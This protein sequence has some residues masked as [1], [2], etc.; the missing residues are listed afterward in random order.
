MS[1]SH[2]CLLV[3]R[4][5]HWCLEN[6][7]CR[8]GLAPLEVPGHLSDPAHREVLVL[9]GPT[10]RTERG[11]GSIWCC[12]GTSGL[13]GGRGESVRARKPFNLR[14][15]TEMSLSRC[16][17]LLTLDKLFAHL[18]CDGAHCSLGL[19]VAL[20]KPGFKSLRLENHVVH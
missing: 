8:R 17:T 9:F 7:V 15:N 4:S 11:S 10:W 20:M 16:V 3:V 2:L 6:R 13:R 1:L 14:R 19:H 5:G 12:S 18:P